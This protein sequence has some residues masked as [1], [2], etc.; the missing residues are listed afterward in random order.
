[1]LL[2]LIVA[3]A[4]RHDVVSEHFS[5]TDNKLTP[6]KTN[7]NVL[8]AGSVRF[9]VRERV[10]NSARCHRSQCVADVI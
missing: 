8:R 9:L 4:E 1:M 10:G 2:F 3:D 6:C 5:T 7:V